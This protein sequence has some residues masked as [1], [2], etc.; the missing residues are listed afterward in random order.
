MRGPSPSADT[1]V[2]DD[3]VEADDTVGRVIVVT[4]RGNG[5]VASVKSN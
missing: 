1:D 2:V 5:E 3:A 4:T